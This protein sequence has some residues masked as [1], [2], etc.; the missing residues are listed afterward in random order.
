MTLALEGVRVLELARVAPHFFCTMML[1]DMGAEVLKIETPLT[2]ES[3]REG[4]DE[5]LAGQ[6]AARKENYAYLNRN[7]RSIAIDLK[8]PE[9]KEVLYQ[10]AR[11]TDVVV[12]G[13]RP[14]VVKRLG[15]DYETLSRINPR[16][17]FCS[18]TGYGQDGPYR[19]LPG[20][21]I[22]YISLAGALGLIGDKGGRPVPPLNLIADYAGGSLHSIIGILMALVARERT[23][24]GQYID[25]SMADAVVSLISTEIGSY[26]NTGDPPRRGEGFLSGSTPCYAVYATK[27]EKWISLGCLEPHFWINLCRALGREDYIPHQW[28]EGQ[29]KDEIASFLKQTFLTRNR[30]EWFELFKDKDIAIGKVYDLDELE[31][32][33]Q[34]QHRRLVVEV[35]DARGKKWKQVGLPIKMSDTPG[36]IK[37]LAPALG[38]HTGEV[39]RELGYT[40]E[41]IAR[42]LQDG[43]VA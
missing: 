17:I 19:L 3:T 36:R 5:P 13:F 16:I 9:G 20:H 18:I 6:W 38:E 12:D 2:A 7:K 40:S 33:P 27:D 35:E 43:T 26:F 10:L 23:G 22:N 11:E 14:G 41:A 8:A 37:G 4:G 25:I 15:V 39:L 42:L 1:S 34:V 32:D 21:D 29:K 28:D 30:D 31:S 24:R